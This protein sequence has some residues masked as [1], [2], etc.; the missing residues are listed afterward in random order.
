MG[1][2]TSG[3]DETRF[4]RQGRR[5]LLEEG[6]AEGQVLDVDAVLALTKVFVLEWSQD[7][8]YKMGEELPADL[9]FY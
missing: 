5:Y 2:E 8:D 4:W 1:W 9:L 6:D 3:L 7:F